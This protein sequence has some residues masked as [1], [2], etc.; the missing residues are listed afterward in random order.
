M[1]VF[2]CTPSPECFL[3]A[4]YDAIPFED[5]VISC[6][7]D[8]Q[9][10]LL[11]EL[12]P[13]AE[14]P[15][16]TAKVIRKLISL[17]PCSVRDISLALRCGVPE[18]ADMIFRYIKLLI[19]RG[20]PVR[21]AYG[22]AEVMDMESLKHKVTHEIDKLKGLI[23]FME[24]EDGTLYAPYTPDCDIT[25]LLMPHF[26]ARLPGRKFIIHDL[27]RHLAGISN[28]EDYIITP[29]GEATITLADC[30]MQYESLWKRYYNA[31]NIEARRNDR[32][33]KGYMP[34]RYWKFLPEKS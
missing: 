30:E 17:D 33:M 32:Q 31:V 12:I 25:E 27:G 18:R 10:G 3:T 6:E 13:V 5:S 19:K 1:K 7:Q 22:Y 4:V 8:R 26:L 23:R 21:E 29:A 24:C 9:I 34:V 14:D 15:E 11:D 20:R 2:L 28:G 16:K